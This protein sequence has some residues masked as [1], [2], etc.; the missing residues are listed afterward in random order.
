MQLG[1]IAGAKKSLIELLDKDSEVQLAKVLATAVDRL[2]S[3][4]DKEDVELAKKRVS[5]L[6]RY[7]Y[8]RNADME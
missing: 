2:L 3:R 4:P 6:P 1:D 8:P 7:R 5:E